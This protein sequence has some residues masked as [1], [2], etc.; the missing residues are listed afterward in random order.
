LQTID[1]LA[2]KIKIKIMNKGK[3]KFFIEDKGYGFITEDETNIDYFIHI[4]NVNGEDHLQEGDE[5]EFEI[6]EGKKGINAV[7][8]NICEE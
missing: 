3:V 1:E 8:V 5:V 4:S 6:E 2:K 7:N